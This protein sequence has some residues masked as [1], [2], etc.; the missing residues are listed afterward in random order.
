MAGF[1]VSAARSDLADLADFAPGAPREPLPF[2]SAA[3]RAWTEQR[4]VHNLGAREEALR[5][6]LWARADL[7]K[8]RT[9]QDLPWSQTMMG[10]LI[11]PTAGFTAQPYVTDD[12][13][14]RQIEDL[15]AKRP[16]AMAGVPTLAQVRAQVDAKLRAIALQGAE[17]AQD[18]PVAAFLGSSAGGLTD[19]PNLAAMLLGNPE[20][21][22]GRSL[23]L[24]LLA[25]GA[26]TGGLQVGATAAFAPAKVLEAEGV[27]G[28]AYGLPEAAGDV[29]GAAVGG[30]AF[31]IGGGLV[32]LGARRLGGRLFEA[33][34]AARG[35]GEA[36]DRWARD[37]QAIGPDRDG[38]DYDAALG[39]LDAGAPPPPVEP[40]RNLEELFPGDPLAPP[41]LPARNEAQRPD[42]LS[43]I[44]DRAE[45]RGRPIHAAAFDPR[46]V[47]AAPEV[48]QY[49][50]GGDAEGV[51]ARLR[52]VRAWDPVS[53]G[54]VLVWEDAE[55][56]RFIADG[57]QR[58]GLALRL[59]QAG[60]EPKL[61]GYLFRARDGWTAR[62]V[63]LLAALKNIREGQGSPLDAAKVFRDAP[64]H[65]TDDSL[66]ISGEFIAQARALAKLHPDA[67]AAVVN[68]LLPE[69]YAAAIGELA[70]DRPD[71]HAGMVK[72]LRDGEPANVDEARA[73]VQEAKLDDWIARQ[74]EQTDLFGGL[75]PEA[76]TIARAKVKAV[77]LRALSADARIFGQ[78]V[79]HADAIE[80]GGNALARDANE[81]ALAVNRAAL[82]IV[83][84]LSL[85]SGPI[86]EAL[87]EAAKAVL[88][89]RR[90]GDAAKPILQRIK[91]ALAAGERLD[92]LRGETIDPPPPP[93]AAVKA[94]DAFSEPGGK[95][96]L[97]QL[98]PKP[99]DAALEA[100]GF[101]GTSE[102]LHEFEFAPG[103]FAYFTDSLA[104]AQEYADVHATTG[105]VANIRTETIRLANAERIDLAGAPM[106]SFLK[107]P[108]VEAAIERAQ[109]TGK[110]VVVIENTND[111]PGGAT[112]GAHTI[113]VVLNRK[114]L[115]REAL[116]LGL[117][118]DLDP[119]DAHQKALDRLRPC[120]PGD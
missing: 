66:P 11:D 54:K 110:D 71:L 49:K 102:P 47:A 2:W 20:V 105:G 36:L 34:P 62:E 78:L 41:E 88:A 55:G 30:A 93:E 70:A 13:Y 107:D 10:Q 43:Q 9:G 40:R 15:R 59:E 27:G 72:L 56:R 26:V 74:G 82:E 77:V 64:A 97:E 99:E 57:H 53:S 80:A 63:R 31:E 109:T 58:R 104:L 111:S 101:H 29:L 79:R 5:E 12:A 19:T 113:Y 45:Y 83:S 108:R 52:G 37:D 85:R 17:A 67:F 86:G 115:K 6:A 21:A 24:R 94:L 65:L 75:A 61:D 51:T 73:L 96:Q 39:A 68:G 89:G 22:V 114:G 42:S 118:D 87:A 32:R 4:Q 46:E 112:P 76:T 60:F 100:V 95:G 7:I 16:Q 38:G 1:A 90:P 44:Y 84:R 116:P 69:R 48:F 25:R 106:G 81:Q 33:D 8:R 91:A 92:A 35:M 18:H 3:H 119:G 14:E 50:A 23:A 98:K 28:P 117:F 120:A 103:K